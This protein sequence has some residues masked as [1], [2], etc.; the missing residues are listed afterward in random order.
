MIFMGCLILL[1]IEYITINQQVRCSDPTTIC[2]NRTTG[3][4]FILIRDMTFLPCVLCLQCEDVTPSF[5][6][7]LKH[8]QTHCFLLNSD[9]RLIAGTTINIW[10]LV[11]GFLVSSNCN[12]PFVIHDASLKPVVIVPK[13]HLA[14]I[15]VLLFALTARD[16]INS[17]HFL[18]S[19][20]PIKLS[21][22]YCKTC[23]NI[24]K[25]TNITCDI[26]IAKRC[27][28]LHTLPV[29]LFECTADILGLLLE[30]LVS[31]C[32]GTWPR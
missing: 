16:V 28:D 26:K 1:P 6:T 11:H 10:H 32:N 8:Q 23:L 30:G 22:K 21:I 18:Q 25:T 29:I 27:T 3:T 9:V 2:L 17:L 5:F 12:L 15:L 13:Q 20:H 14:C 24:G 4:H 19:R 31:K 7:A